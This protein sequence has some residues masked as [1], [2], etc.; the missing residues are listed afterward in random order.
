MTTIPS[1]TSL[2]FICSTRGQT[3]T[4]IVNSG[5]YA[6]VTGGTT[7]Q[8]MGPSP[9]RRTFGPFEVGDSRTIIATFGDIV[10]D[11]VQNTASTRQATLTSDYTLTASDD[12]TIFSATTAITVTVPAGLSPMPSCVFLPPATGSITL[13]PTGGTLLSGS[14]SDV[15]FSIVSNPAG[16]GLVPLYG[17]TDKYGVTVA[18]TSWSA[19][20]GV[21]SDSTAWNTAMAAYTLKPS[22]PA[23]LSAAYTVAASDNGGFLWL[24]AQ[25]VDKIISLPASIATSAPFECTIA[26]ANTTAAA[27][28]CNIKTSGGSVIV[29]TVNQSTGAQA[30]LP[31]GLFMGTASAN[32]VAACRVFSEGAAPGGAFIVVPLCGTF[33]TA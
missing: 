24:N 10:V 9:S 3:F 16:A 28:R 14:S 27:G 6:T 1:G 29:S 19:L 32:N 33:A 2:G 13:H 21:P 7:P 12:N 11:L 26:Y 23:K 18:S 31:N 8:F 15:A 20:S 4:V 25:T 30:T 22:A 5:Q 17:Q